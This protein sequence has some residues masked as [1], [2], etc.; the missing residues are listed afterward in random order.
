MIMVRFSFPFRRLRLLALLVIPLVGWLSWRWLHSEKVHRQPDDPRLAFATP[1]R[2]VRPEVKYVGSEVCAS[3]HADQAVPFRRHPMGQSLAPIK[4]AT[5]LEQF[6]PAHHNPFDAFGFQFLVERKEGIQTHKEIRQDPRSSAKTEFASEINFAVG[7]GARGRTYLIDHEGYLFESAI[8]WYSQKGIWDLSP[9]FASNPHSDRPITA[10]CLFCHSNH[11]DPV[12]GAINHY[13]SPIFQGYAIGCERC[14][15]PGELHAARR[16]QGDTS[17]G[18]DETIVNPAR[19]SPSLRNAVCEQ[20]HLQ[21]EMRILHPGRKIFD[22]R[23]GLPWQLFWTVFLKPGDDSDTRQAVGQVE[24]M[25]E[26]RC[27][28]GG[29]LV[30]ISCHDPHSAPEPAIRADYYRRRCL[31]C[32]TPESCS[33]PKA[34]NR[35]SNP[36][37]PVPPVANHSTTGNTGNTGERALDSSQDCIRCHMPRK[38]SSDVAHTAMT[39]H[40]ILRLP[41]PDP[42]VPRVP[43]GQEPNHGGHGDHGATIF[44][45][46]PSVLDQFDPEHALTS[47]ALGLAM[48]RPAEFGTADRQAR[49][50]QTL[51]ALKRLDAA[52]KNVPDD[53]P[54]LEARGYALWQQNRNDDAMKC[55]E[56]ALSF[57]PENE[58]V[59][60]YAAYLAAEMGQREKAVDMWRRALLVNPWSARSHYELSRLFILRQEWAQAMDEARFVLRLNPFHIGARKLLVVCL[61]G[62]GDLPGAR[63]EFNRLLELNPPNQDS[64]QKWFDQQRR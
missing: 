27:Y 34:E 36:K 32:H 8:T 42:G 11:V 4:E 12:D 63:A 29:N 28:S 49:S 9:G 60:I 3:C 48:V 59:L 33:N 56:A 21:G 16:E 51:D 17:P 45:P 31:A 5:A 55:F 39:D 57:A 40:R 30:C 38:L 54:A 22:Y 53:I 58:V 25:H 37:I 52:V 6:E 18:P 2:N 13:R 41:S 10:E 64:L 7:S 46:E 47:R 43:R 20:C 26:S 44:D 14:H 50:R 19:L 1:F 24:Q 23:P 61:Q 15:G 35:N 62:K